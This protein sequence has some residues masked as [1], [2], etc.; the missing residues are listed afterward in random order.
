MFKGQNKNNLFNNIHGLPNHLI[1]IRASLTH[2]LEEAWFFLNG[3]ESN[4]NRQNYAGRMART[5]SFQVISY[6]SSKLTDHGSTKPNCHFKIHINDATSTVK[7]ML[8][9]RPG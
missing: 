5:I 7:T 8:L 2:V 3:E 1:L 4:F 6:F 9:G